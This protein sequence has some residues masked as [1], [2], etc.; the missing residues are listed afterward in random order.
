IEVGPDA[1][2]TALGPA[3][4]D[5][6]VFI[7]AQRSAQPGAET[8]IEALARAHTHGTTLH[9]PAILPPGQRVDLPTY[10]FQHQR[11]WP[12]PTAAP[13]LASEGAGTVG[14]ARFWAAVDGSDVSQVAAVLGVS[15]QERLDGLLPALAAWRR[16]QHDR[17]VTGTWRYRV[18]W[19]PVSI[20]GPAPAPAETGRPGTG[21]LGAEGSG[22]G[23]SAAELSGT[24]LA[25]SELSGTW[26][27][28]APA[29]GHPLVA[30]VAA[31]ISA[32]GGHAHVVSPAALDR[33]PLTAALAASA[34]SS[35]IASS[36][37]GSAV[38]SAFAASA[39]SGPF[40]SAAGGEAAA[41]IGD[42]AAVGDETR[43]GAPGLAAGATRA[44]AGVVSLLAI[45]G[46]GSAVAV[47]SAEAGPE[48][49]DAG[50]AGYRGV[51]AGTAGTLAL[52]QALGDAEIEAPMWA[53]T[54]GAV[55]AGPGDMVT[56]PVQAQVWGLGRVAA[57][58]HPGRWGGLI[59]LP[60]TLDDRTAGQ[61]CGLLAGTSAENE[62]A[63]RPAGTLARRLAR[64][65]QPRDRNHEPGWQPSGTVLV[66][67]GTGAI[68]THVARW[69]ATQRG[70]QRLILTSR[71]GPNKAG[72]GAL[73][74]GLAGAGATVTIAAADIADRD[75]TGALLDWAG[76]TGPPLR[77]IF[78]TA[79]AEES[80][81]LA[82]VSAVDLARVARAK[83]AGAALLDELTA[84]LDIEAFVLF[85]SIAATW[86]SGRQP[87]YAAANAYLDALAEHRRARGLPATSVAW[88]PW[89][90]GGMTTGPAA[91]GLRRR[92][93]E[94]LRPERALNVLGHAVDDGDTNLTVAQ[95]AWDRF[96]PTF[97]IHR[98][99][100]LLAALPEA[101]RVLASQAEER[102]RTQPGAV[103]ELSQRLAGVGVG[104]RLGV[105]VD[106]V[107]E[108]VAGVLGFG[109]VGEVAAGR[110]FRDLGFD[111]LTA[112]ELR[113]RLGVVTG[114]GL[115]AT[116][117]FDYPSP[118]V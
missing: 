104:G 39:P 71:S 13:S 58:E 17:A 86:G 60:P 34:S 52:I 75:A 88:G 102:H 22:S 26:L 116:V 38:S 3:I 62:T 83:A 44:V 96:V 105:V 109:S 25:W 112:V 65:P 85:S 107:C 99:S 41:V 57:L 94:L 15:D 110:V 20:P 72:T 55:R 100:P 36:P 66:T 90:G 61:L 6:S 111:S 2:L 28:V 101:Q 29:G 98:P 54:R 50:G 113:N 45:P 35:A 4:T 77:A 9:W 114:L 108:Q 30:Q 97:T 68:G 8:L 81:A 89:A 51:P 73:A 79:G 46:T 67:G 21:R 47:G 18:I 103:T 32:H 74:A 84:E 87:A 80:A 69:L 82:D 5:R 117:V 10:A 63:I 95:V 24:G 42:A 23:L 106:V 12:T 7:A 76:Q 14:E 118:L 31:A 59:D 43:L 91:I 64:A 37:S 115:P 78:H 19:V 33:A 93:L 49:V 53:L 48:P 92:G 27:V 40:A 16:G 70:A 11:Y 1:T 56:D